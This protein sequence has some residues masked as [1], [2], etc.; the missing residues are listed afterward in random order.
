MANN[1]KD[2]AVGLDIPIQAFQIYLY[3]ALKKKALWPVD[4]TN[5]EGHGKVYRNA[6]DRGYV[7]EVFV[8]S[9]EPN[10][11]IYKP[12]VFDKVR[13]KAMFFFTT[14]DRATFL[15][16]S[17]TIK[18]SLIFITNIALLKDKIKHRG[19]EEVRNDVMKLCSTNYQNFILTGTETGFG[20]VFRSFTGLV[21]KDGEVFEDRHPL[22]CFKLNFDLFYQP[23]QVQC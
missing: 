13:H 3:K 7:P 18:I 19:D 21:N 2:N 9:T 22:Y 6:N 8:S 15:D 20:N 11:T 5:L 14:E 12:V 4:D 1:L 10:N 23:T 16:G 17:E